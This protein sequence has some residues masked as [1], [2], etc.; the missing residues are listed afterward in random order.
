MAYWTHNGHLLLIT[1]F[2]SVYGFST[3][4][5]AIHFFLIRFTEKQQRSTSKKSYAICSQ[6]RWKAWHGSNFQV[7]NNQRSTN[8]EAPMHNEPVISTPISVS[9]TWQPR[10][11]QKGNN[12]TDTSRKRSYEMPW[13]PYEEWQVGPKRCTE[14]ANRRFHESSSQS[15][16]HHTNL[17]TW[18]SYRI[19]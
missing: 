8:V 14:C 2:F 16:L 13:S 10:Q 4:K 19:L 11:T 5:Q 15:R 7:G 17:F 12:I 3:A 1:R 18:L 6:M 9:S